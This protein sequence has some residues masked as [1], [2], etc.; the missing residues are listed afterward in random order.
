MKKAREVHRRIPGFLPETPD[1]GSFQ[2]LSL[3]G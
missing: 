1:S 2:M 3:S